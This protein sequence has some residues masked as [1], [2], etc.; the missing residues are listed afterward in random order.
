MKRLAAVVAGA[1]LLASVVVAGAGGQ[2]PPGRTLVLTE[3]AKGGRFGFVDNPPKV[4]RTKGRAPRLSVGDLL[5]FSSPIADQQGSRVG[6]L[7]VQCVVS[8]P[9][10]SRTA[11]Q[12]CTGVFRLKDGLIGV[13]AALAGEPTTVSAIVTGGTG[14][15]EGARGTLTSVSHRNGSSTDTLHLLP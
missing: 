4:K 1:A 11:E 14:A 12:V 5:V 3:L 13:A 8:V 7:H 10:T 9:G 15:Y 2:A 6:R